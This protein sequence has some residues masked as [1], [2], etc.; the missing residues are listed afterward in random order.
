MA[1]CVI[2]AVLCVLVSLSIV[3]PHATAR[4]DDAAPDLVQSVPLGPISSAVAGTPVVDSVTHVLFEATYSVG[5]DAANEVIEVNDLTGETIRELTLAPGLSVTSAVL[6]V[7]DATDTLYFASAYSVEAFDAATGAEIGLIALPA[8]QNTAVNGISSVAVDSVTHDMLVGLGAELYEIGAGSS[9]VLAQVALPAVIYSLA[10]D[11][12]SG[13]AFTSEPYVGLAKVDLSTFTVV[14][15]S[16]ESGTIDALAVDHGSGQIFGR[17]SDNGVV[18]ALGA[19][20]ESSLAEI[21]TPLTSIQNFV[22]DPG[23]GLV[24]VSN[25]YEDTFYELDTSSDTVARTLHMA[26]QTTFNAWAADLE[27]GNVFD[28]EDQYSGGLTGV[29]ATPTSLTSAAPPA[30]QT[31]MSYSFPLSMSPAGVFWSVTSGTLP[32]GLSLDQTTGVL[33]GVPTTVGSY[34][35]SVTG[36]DPSG[37]GSTATYTQAISL[38]RVVDQVYGPDRYQTSVEVAQAAFPE[39]ANVV[40]IADGNNFPDALSAG[41]A[42]AKMGGPVLLTASDSL[43]AAVAAEITDLDPAQIIVVG[44]TSAVSNTVQAQLTK[45]VSNTVRWSGADRYATSRT[46]DT[47]A[48]GPGGIPNIFVATGITFPDALSAGAAAGSLDYPILLVDGSEG[49]LDSAS[50]Q[51]LAQFN[52]ANAYIVGGTGAI[53][54]GIG[55]SLYYSVSGTVSRFSGSDRYQTAE[56][57]NEAVWDADGTNASEPTSNLAFLVT[58][59]NFPD[60]LSAGPWAGGTGSPMYLVPG[61]CVPNQVISDLNGLGVSLVVLVGGPTVLTRP[62]AELTPCDPTAAIVASSKSTR[63]G[64]ALVIPKL[65]VSS[66]ASN[67]PNSKPRLGPATP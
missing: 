17:V 35:Y 53:S 21:S 8:P 2:A 29:L 30:G 64:S 57:I 22:L 18:F 11:S 49:T 39:S 13:V 28:T 56:Q 1:R 7:D 67:P 3:V 19:F 41:P 24:Y 32:P 31:W 65:N 6:A 54:S 9:A 38:N 42:A 44:G 27:T 14:A 12:T 25:A 20:S 36:R 40:F 62:V 50:A 61:N 59:L 37:G 33:S 15:T 48:F 26:P 45:L 16:A 5:D 23:R 51:F 4:A 46:I 66:H 58:G 52:V 60:A 47:N 43:P 10:V 55:D 34:T 63:N